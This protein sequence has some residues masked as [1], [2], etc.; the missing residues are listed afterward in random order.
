MAAIEHHGWEG[1]ELVVMVG[2]HLAA[3]L[4]GLGGGILGGYKWV[5]RRL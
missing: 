1:W 5:R 3:V 4:W 2:A